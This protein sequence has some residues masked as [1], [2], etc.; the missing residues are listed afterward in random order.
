VNS[1]RV[2]LVGMLVAVE[3]LIAGLAI[4]SVSGTHVWAAGHQVDYTAKTVAT[5]DAGAAPQVVV[6]DPDSRVIV[7]VSPD[8]KVHVKDMTSLH[9]FLF[10]TDRSIPKLNATRT[11]DGVLIERSPYQDNWMHLTIGE[12][13]QRI[14]V[15]V[16]AGAHLDIQK[17]SGADVA[18]LRADARVRS[19]DGHI[20][21]SDIQGTIDASSADGY[22]N[23]SG[24]RGDSLTLQ[25]SDGHISLRDVTAQSLSARSN[26]GRVEATNLTMSGAAPKATLHSDDGSIHVNG[27]FPAG[28]TYDVSSNDGRVELGLASGSDVTVVAS[29]G[30][31][32]IYVDGKSPGDD[33]RQHQT[34]K[35]G[36][37]SGAMRVSSGDG[38]IH[39]TTN[40]AF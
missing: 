29:T 13:M 2:A 32:S 38:S 22:I 35:I 16:P 40:G 5:I 19:Q 39:L 37:G 1:G 12:S 34:I 15:D 26:D 6:S 3:V 33:D 11:A 24:V 4:W 21:L 14:E 23:A 28:G 10:S 20:T 31:G 17:C 7:G 36:S 25:S 9:G 8:G 18:G 30:D 27:T